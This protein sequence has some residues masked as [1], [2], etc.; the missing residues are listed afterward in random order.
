FQHSR[1]KPRTF[2]RRLFFE[3]K[4]LDILIRYPAILPGNAPPCFISSCY[5]HLQLW[6]T[7]NTGGRCWPGKGEAR[8]SGQEPGG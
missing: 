4:S 3:A 8:S 5:F 6:L 2:Q 7:Y 1:S